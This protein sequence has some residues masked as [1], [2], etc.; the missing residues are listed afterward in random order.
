M[1]LAMP[2]GYRFRNPIGSIVQAVSEKVFTFIACCYLT[3]S[4]HKKA[5]LEKAGRH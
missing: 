3:R 5:P 1:E 2:E 4:G